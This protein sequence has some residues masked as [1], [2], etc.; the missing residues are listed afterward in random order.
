MDLDL[1]PNADVVALGEVAV[2]PTC[3]RIADQQA[4]APR[5]GARRLGK[6]A[7]TAGARLAPRAPSAQHVRA[8]QHT[9]PEGEDMHGFEAQL[10][11]QNFMFTKSLED[12]EMNMQIH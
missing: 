12:L 2:L 5:P 4:P 11:Q 8:E 1:R 9:L 10:Q 3:K 7:V 6:D